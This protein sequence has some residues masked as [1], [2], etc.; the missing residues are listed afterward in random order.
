[1]CYTV[2]LMPMNQTY[3]FSG[4][5]VQAMGL[6][7]KIAFILFEIKIQIEM[8][9]SISRPGILFYFNFIILYLMP[10]V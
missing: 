5:Q 4:I 1:M 6:T 2:K 9:K 7:G 3:V 10:L 8:N